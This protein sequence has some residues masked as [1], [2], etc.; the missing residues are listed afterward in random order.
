S[1]SAIAVGSGNQSCVGCVAAER[2]GKKLKRR[3]NCPHAE[4]RNDGTR[5]DF[6]ERDDVWMVT[7]HEGDNAREVPVT[8]GGAATM[9]VP[10]H[11][12]NVAGPSL[13]RNIHK[14]PRC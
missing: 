2:A 14:A 10:G 4:P 11:H 7:V 9:N 1:M 3:P 13:E 6:L 8:A 5:I 12:S